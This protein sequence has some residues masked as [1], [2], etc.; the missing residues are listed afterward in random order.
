MGTTTTTSWIP[1]GQYTASLGWGRG[2]NLKSPT[3]VCPSGAA[4]TII[5][6]G[7]YNKV[8]PDSVSG[9]RRP[10]QGRN[11]TMTVPIYT[12]LDQHPSVTSSTFKLSPT[13]LQPPTPSSSH[14]PTSSSHPQHLSSRPPPDLQPDTPSPA[15]LNPGLPPANFG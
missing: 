2:R 15:V 3:K 14:P 11:V 9:E 13:L 4:S 6:F 12:V 10:S 1:S 8:V 5:K 7:F